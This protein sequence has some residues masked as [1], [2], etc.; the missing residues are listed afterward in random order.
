MTT[1]TAMLA[2]MSRAKMREILIQLSVGMKRDMRQ[3]ATNHRLATITYLRT[4]VA[5][6]GKFADTIAAG[7]T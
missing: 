6:C 1:T 5:R 4:S 7:V 3:F 2:V